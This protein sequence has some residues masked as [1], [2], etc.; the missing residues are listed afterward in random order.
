MQFND[1]PGSSVWRPSTQR[2]V[3][4]ITPQEA[5]CDLTATVLSVALRS[6]EGGSM[7]A[8]ER[9]RRSPPLMNPTVYSLSKSSSVSRGVSNKH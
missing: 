5:E 2:S 4:P 9:G 3:Q 7:S 8:L 6:V 1:D